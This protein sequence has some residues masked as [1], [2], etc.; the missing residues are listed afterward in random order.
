MTVLSLQPPRAPP[1]HLR[2]QSFQILSRLR[3]IN[4]FRPWLEYTRY[5]IFRKHQTPL[6]LL[7]DCFSFGA[8]L[9]TLLTLLGSPAPTHLIV[10]VE[11]FNFGIGIEEREEYFMSFI[12]RVQMLEMQNRVPYGEVLRCDDFLSGT[13]SAFTKVCFDTLSVYSRL[14]S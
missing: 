6:E 4:E 3:L 2:L 1:D 10:H 8:P 5:H 11:D 13:N 12:L 7:W 14:M 9:G